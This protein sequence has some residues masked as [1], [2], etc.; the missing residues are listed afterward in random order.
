[1]KHV[2]GHTVRSEHPSIWCDDCARLV[3][4]EEHEATWPPPPSEA[5][6]EAAAR[7]QIGMRDM[8]R[9]RQSQEC[10]GWE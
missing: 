8:D 3:T 2:A 9:I 10:G 6:E 4:R 7:E 1:M 5:E